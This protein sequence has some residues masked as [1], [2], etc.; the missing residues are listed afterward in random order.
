[1]YEEQR[2]DNNSI[3]GVL[4][5]PLAPGSQ[6]Q[7]EHPPPTD[8]QRNPPEPVKQAS[9]YVAIRSRPLLKHEVKAGLYEILR[10]MDK[11]V[12]LLMIHQ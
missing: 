7:E 10:I 3:Q 8:P 12:S 5:R 6:L 1:M 11:K 4:S 9:L 2:N